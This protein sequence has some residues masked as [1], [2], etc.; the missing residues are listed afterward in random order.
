[1]TP[2]RQSNRTCQHQTKRITRAA[3]PHLQL[4]RALWRRDPVEQGVDQV[5]QVRV[6]GHANVRRGDI[7][8]HLVRVHV[9]AS[10]AD[11]ATAAKVEAKRVLTRDSP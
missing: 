3:T 9:H 11:P 10:Q 1:M 6:H 8:L 2:Q 7:E 4:L 5:P